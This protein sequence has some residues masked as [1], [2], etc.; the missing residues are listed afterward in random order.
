MFCWAAPAFDSVFAICPQSVCCH[1]L[2]RPVQ[3]C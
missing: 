3:S 1:I 2:S